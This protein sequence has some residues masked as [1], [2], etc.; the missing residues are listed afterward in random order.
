[1]E[2][3]NGA[4]AKSYMRKDFLIYEEMR[5]YFPIYEDAVSHILKVWLLHEPC[6]TSAHGEYI[7]YNICIIGCSTLNKCVF[8]FSGQT[9]QPCCLGPFYTVDYPKAPL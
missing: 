7:M 8:F 1:M 5:K 4:V 3:Q 9:E 6:K 2:I